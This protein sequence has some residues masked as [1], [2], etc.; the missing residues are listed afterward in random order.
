MK[1]S[2]LLILLVATIG[3]GR[4]LCGRFAQGY[5]RW[6][7]LLDLPCMSVPLIQM[8]VFHAFNYEVAF[9]TE[10]SDCC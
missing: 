3:I 2:N 8:L 1:W 10:R 7:G 9:F 6:A 5:Y 4:I